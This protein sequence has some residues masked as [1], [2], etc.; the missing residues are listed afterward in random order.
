MGVFIIMHESEFAIYS[1]VVYQHSLHVLVIPASNAKTPVSQGKIN[2]C[3]Q[4][5]SLAKEIHV[6]SSA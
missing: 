6:N 4:D 5:V 1:C 2:M 3:L